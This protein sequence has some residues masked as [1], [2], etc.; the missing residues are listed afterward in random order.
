MDALLDLL[1]NSINAALEK[2]HDKLKRPSD[3]IGLL[4]KARPSNIPTIDVSISDDR[5]SIVDTCGGISLETARDHVFRFGRPPADEH[6]DDDDTLSVY[7]IGLKRALFKLGNNIKMRSEHPDGGF[8]M[9]LDVKKW[10]AL[11]Q[12]RW[13]IPLDGL[14]PNTAAPGTQISVDGL[15]PDIKKRVGDGK[16]VGD[17][18]YRIARTYIYFLERVVSVKVNGQVVEPI[19]LKFGSN[20]ASDVFSLGDVSC[21]IIAGV[22]LPSGKF[23]VAETAGWYIFCNGRAVAFADKSQLTGW[24]IFL[25]S[26]Q[27]KHR[28]F[29][30]LVFFTSQ[31]PEELPWTTTKSSVN[32]ESVVWQQAIRA[33]GVAG[34]QITSYLDS[35][36]DDLGTQISTDEL[37]DAAGTSKS[38]FTS[39]PSTA[40]RFTVT[41]TKKTTTSIQFPVKISEIDEVKSYLGGNKSNSEVGRITFDYYLDNVVRD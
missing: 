19:E 14:E 26:F 39:V 31:N 15:H 22:S 2:E 41:K 29:L 35:R 37:R 28:P 21:S 13:E 32:Q 9:A 40:Q 36:Y 5:V 7:G 8:S 33:M 16:F 3:Y 12:A 27:P 4:Q 23:Y 11:N 10:G 24:G 30:G 34:K 18:V 6:E 20:V 1:D 38:A 25:P 17:L